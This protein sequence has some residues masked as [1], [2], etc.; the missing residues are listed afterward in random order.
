MSS[1]FEIKGLY[2]NWSDEWFFCIL[3][4]SGA[5]C[6][7]IGGTLSICLVYSHTRRL[8]SQAIQDSVVV[9]LFGY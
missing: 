8:L 7:N 4:T 6:T 5:E 2:P 1:S 9:S 3:Q